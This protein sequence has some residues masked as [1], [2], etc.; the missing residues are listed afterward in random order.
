MKLLQSLIPTLGRLGLKPAQPTVQLTF[1]PALSS[2]LKQEL[3]TLPPQTPL[4][5]TASNPAGTQA[6]LKLPSGAVITASVHPAIPQG[7]QVQ[8][9]P[10]ELLNASTRPGTDSAP[11][12]SPSNPTQTQSVPAR[13]VL[14]QTSGVTAPQPNPTP[15]PP[16]QSVLV[17]SP[18]S[19]I[20]HAE[21][22]TIHTTTVL[23]TT[24]Q[25]AITAATQNIAATAQTIAI[26]AQVTAPQPTLPVPP[27]PVAVALPANLAQTLMGQ[28]LTLT[29]TLP[30]AADGTQQATLVAASVR[31]SMRRPA[32]R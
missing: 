26:T 18:G 29:P 31:P 4:S 16:A 7:A 6:T 3:S 27:G 14:P 11:Q 5:F 19:A 21:L 22:R 8:L 32:N 13:I 24:V 20:T 25:N 17:Q 2:I 28:I 10:A 23:Q 30:M 1:S 15:A 9:N 12:A